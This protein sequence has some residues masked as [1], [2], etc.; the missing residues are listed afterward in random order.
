MENRFEVTVIYRQ[1][2][3]TCPQCGRV[4]IKEHNRR[5]QCRQDG[6][7]REHGFTSGCSSTLKQTSFSISYQAP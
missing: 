5:Q 7:L 1:G 3:A 4:T 6:R 2:E